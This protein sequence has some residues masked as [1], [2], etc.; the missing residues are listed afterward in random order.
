[1]SRGLLAK[2]TDYGDFDWD[3]EPAD[4]QAIAHV[5]RITQVQAIFGGNYFALP[6]TSCWLIWDKLNGK[7][8]FADCELAW[9]NL[10]RAVRIFRH[11]WHGMLRDSEKEKRFHPTQKP[12]ALMKWVIEQLR[13]PEGATILDAYMGCGPVGV[14]AVSMGYNYIGI[15]RDARYFDIAVKRITDARRA[16]EGLP[17]QLAGRVEDYADSP[18][19]SGVS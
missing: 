7:T 19:F 15:E 14:A 9:T 6:P 17:K 12:V 11:R 10:D 5:L 8:D 3:Q 16:A 1:M 2:P 4:P 13:I 18:L